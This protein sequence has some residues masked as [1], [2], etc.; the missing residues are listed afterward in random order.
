[1]IVARILLR[2]NIGC[3]ATAI[4]GSAE[5][6]RPL[7]VCLAGRLFARPHLLPK[8]VSTRRTSKRITAPM[9]A[10]MTA[11]IKPVPRLIMEIG[12]QKTGDYGADDTDRY[13]AKKAEAAA[14]GRPCRRAS[15]LWHQQSAK[16]QC[17]V[18]GLS[19]IPLSRKPGPGAV[20]RPDG[21]NNSTLGA[22]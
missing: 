22:L 1:L 13:V 16:Q 19:R 4:R 14:P 9:K 6:Q 2:R 17:F 8:P 5:A 12:K 3:A 20:S 10:S 15:R 21:G 11:L 18:E 7:H